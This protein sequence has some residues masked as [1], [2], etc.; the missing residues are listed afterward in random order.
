MTKEPT[1]REILEKLLWGCCMLCE[2]E[3]KTPQEPLDL[4]HQEIRKKLPSVEEIADEIEKLYSCV[5]GEQFEL[6]RQLA[7]AIHNL[8]EERMK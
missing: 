3:D 2:K 7:T 1:I 8:L 5:D 6:N 4:A